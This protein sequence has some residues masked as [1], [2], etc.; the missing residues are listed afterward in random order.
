MDQFSVACGYNELYG[1]K[2]LSDLS[3]DERYIVMK[4][5]MLNKSDKKKLKDF[6]ESNISNQE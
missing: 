2:Y 1:E 5:R 3:D 4:Y 6:I